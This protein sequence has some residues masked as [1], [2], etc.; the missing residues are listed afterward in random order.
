VKIDDPCC[1]LTA[2]RMVVMRL[3]GGC[4]MPIGAYAATSERGLTLTAVVVSLDGA[5]W[6][7]TEARG[8]L[9][10]AELVG[11]RAAVDLLAGG[12]AE[13]LAEAERARAA[14]ERPQT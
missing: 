1:A 5:R 10:E 7:H 14:V 6:A 11:T 8:A 12:A 4:Q 3:G 13:I 2:E 9:S